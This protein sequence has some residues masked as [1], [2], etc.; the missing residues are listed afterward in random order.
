MHKINLDFQVASKPNV[1]AGWL[2]LL[3]GGIFCADVFWGYM[4]LK[5]EVAKTRGG[6]QFGLVPNA[7][8]NA[9]ASVQAEQYEQALGVVDNLSLPWG[10]LFSALESVPTT[11]IGILEFTPHPQEHLLVLRGEAANFPAMLTYIAALEQNPIF[12]NVYLEKH[13]LKKGGQANSISFMLSAY[14]VMR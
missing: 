3:I 10:S 1:W 6:A 4:S 7:V 14:W 11:D 5:D 12:Y 2:L 9:S 13:E 8:N